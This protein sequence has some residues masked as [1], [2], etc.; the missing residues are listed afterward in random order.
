[1]L[2]AVSGHLWA[3][4]AI[5]PI[6]QALRWLRRAVLVLGLLG[7][8]AAVHAQPIS[9]SGDA[10]ADEALPEATSKAAESMR[11][12]VHTAALQR[13]R[14]DYVAALATAREGLARAQ[15]L[16]DVRMQVEFLY[17]TGRIQWSLT[18]YPRAIETHLL[19]LRLAK[20]LNDPKLLARTHAALGLTYHRFGQIAAGL[21]HFNEALKLAQE[22]G[23]QAQVAMVLNN[24]GNHYLEQ[25]DYARAKELHTQALRIRESLGLTRAIADSYTNLGL[26]ADATGDTAGALQQLD[27]ALEVYQRFGMKRYIANTHRRLTAVLR[28]AGDLVGAQAH[29][30]EALGLAASLGSAEV[31]ANIYEEG[32][33]LDEAKGDFRGALDFQRKLAE[34]T[35]TMR[36]ER[37]RQRIAELRA[38]FDADQ[39]EL[40]I[41]LLRRDQDVQTAEL[42]RGRSQTLALGAGLIL[43]VVIFG[44]V[45]VVQR[46]RLHAERRMRAATQQ[47]R[48]HAE[49]AERLKTRFLQIAS[50]DLK[51]PLNALTATAGLLGRAPANEEAVRRLAQGIQ[52]DTARMAT[53]VRDFLDAAAIED[54]NLEMHL[55]ELDL[56]ALSREAVAGLQPIAALKRQTL[57]FAAPK[58]LPKVRADADRLRQVFDNLVG[59]ALK[60]TPPEG[61]ID[62]VLGELDNYVFAEV[63][64]T[65]PG[66]QPADFGRLFAPYS[67]LSARPTGKEASMGLGLFITHELLA[68]QG[69]RLEVESQPGQGAVFRFLLPVVSAVPV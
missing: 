26:V 11:A 63:R 15:Q 65:G 62:V 29:L 13:R 35:E 36:G 21:E 58:G 3:G 2:P 42:R 66:L 22:A 4:R 18:D 5:N 43:G 46:V 56:A 52:A 61:A 69:G 67:R 64:D 9:D 34:A 27:R 7:A 55:D 47:A 59:N 23:D 16:G 53:L 33:L 54:G 37:D 14:G 25:K 31:L 10:V 60:F 1:M 6:P 32:A 50:H 8:G 12:L 28:R 68:L 57:T 45:I 39:R 44:A 20:T 49:N 48:E 30:E 17:L 38:Q 40:E 19:E 24:L 51:T 41:R